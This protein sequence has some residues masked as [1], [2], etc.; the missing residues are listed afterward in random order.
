MEALAEL[1]AS[2]GGGALGRDWRWAAGDTHADGDSGSDGRVVQRVGA[3]HRGP[4]LGRIAQG[5]CRGRARHLRGATPETDSKHWHEERARASRLPNR[6][7]PEP[8]WT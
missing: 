2:F 1:R 6:F 7:T 8:E 4:A 5:E 3:L